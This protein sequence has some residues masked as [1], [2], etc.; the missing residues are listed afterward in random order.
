MKVPLNPP[1]EPFSH[2]LKNGAKAGNPNGAPRCGAKSKRTG[3]PCRA[4]AMRNGRCRFHGGK[5]TGPLT[6]E[7]KKRIAEAH[8]T[9]GRHTKESKMNRAE[10]RY[11]KTMLRLHFRKPPRV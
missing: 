11:F 8:T 9:T 4:P 7:G 5:S 2:K 1:D 3:Q 6:E 10:F